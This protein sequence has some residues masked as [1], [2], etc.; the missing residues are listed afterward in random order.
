MGPNVDADADADADADM[1]A[2]V[3]MDADMLLDRDPDADADADAKAEADADPDPGSL[4]GDASLFRGVLATPL[5]V[6]L[7]VRP[8]AEAAT[9]P[10]RMEQLEQLLICHCT[11]TI[12]HR[13][14]RIRPY[15]WNSRQ[16]P[17][18][19]QS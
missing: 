11:A 2:D 6:V 15:R 14:C 13:D 4:L 9:V 16:G 5:P 8:L 18:T 10:P 1:D 7:T 19:G 12:T 17:A 3:D